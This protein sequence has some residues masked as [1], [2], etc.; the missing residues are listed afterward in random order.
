MR[1]SIRAF[2]WL[3]V[4]LLIVVSELTPVLAVSSSSSS[5]AH[6]SA[7][8]AHFMHIKPGKSQGESFHKRE[9]LACAAPS[10]GKQ[11]ECVNDQWLYFDS[12]LS[13]G[14]TLPLIEDDVEI[15]GSLYMAAGSNITVSGLNV[16]LKVDECAVLKATAVVSLSKANTE[17]IR[18]A[19]GTKRGA[20]Y[21]LAS[22]ACDGLKDLQVVI[23]SQPQEC[24]QYKAKI[25]HEQSTSGVYYA[26]IQYSWSSSRC[27]YWWIILISIL[28]ITPAVILLMY[29]LHR[30]IRKGKP[31]TR[32]GVTIHQ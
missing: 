28:L 18:R 1:W 10:P 12:I 5:T 17:A 27:N 9:A 20:K 26:Q 8:R 2:S 32:R 19:K 22:S 31:K 15:Y 16:A 6:A 3:S 25:V 4:V 23:K 14:S 11:Y 21:L 29:L 13:S 7:R 24:R 30:L